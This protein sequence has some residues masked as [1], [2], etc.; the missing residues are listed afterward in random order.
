MQVGLNAG[1]REANTLGARLKLARKQRKMRQEDLASKAGIGQPAISKLERGDITETTAIAKLARA[2]RVPSAW[3]E[4]E[5]DEEP[6]WEAQGEAVEPSALDIRG[7]LATLGAALALEIQDAVRQ[8]VADL[9]KKM[10][11]RRGDSRNQAELATLLEPFTKEA[12]LLPPRRQEFDRNDRNDSDTLQ[13]TNG[14]ATTGEPCES[15]TE[16]K[17][18]PLSGPAIPQ[19]K[20]PK[21]RSSRRQQP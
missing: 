3:L 18:L 13:K 19:P 2:L 6:D 16:R 12:V 1:M 7:A 21:S 10:A 17:M 4:L 9:L 5:T 11:E 8:D 20:K 15:E 14:G